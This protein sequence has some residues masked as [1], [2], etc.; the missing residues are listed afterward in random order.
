MRTVV[1]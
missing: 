1:A